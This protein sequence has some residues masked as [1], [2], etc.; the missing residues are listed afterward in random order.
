M[1]HIPPEGSEAARLPTTGSSLLE[2]LHAAEPLLAVELRPPRSGLSH[3]A[4]IDSW[5]DMYHAARSLARQDVVLFLTDNAVGVAEEENLHH[6]TTNLAQNVEL[7][8]LV[9]FLTCKH[10]LE[11]CVMYAARAASEG[12]ESLTVL[13]GDL[14]A[15]P[16]R[17]VAHAWELRERIRRQV[18]SLTLG[19]WANPHRDPREQADF[20]RAPHFGA[21]YFL[22]QVVSHHHLDRV[23]RF[24]DE[25]DQRGVSYPGL[26]GVFYYRSARSLERLSQFFPVPVQEIAREF[27]A[28]ASAKEICLRT[29][30]ALHDLGINRFYLC[31]LSPEEAPAFVREVREVLQAPPPHLRKHPTRHIA[32]PAVPSPTGRGTG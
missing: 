8:R 15:G 31:N 6:L 24:V 14:A 16:Q 12:L 3:D 32:R 30:R 26:F 13:G 23:A 9:P 28:G 22:T 2:R 29:V 25:I 4:S 20:L 7:S 10:S 17:C 18:P 5:I 21:E 27:E 1:T 11:Y 19:G